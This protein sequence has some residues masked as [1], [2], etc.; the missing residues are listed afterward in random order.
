MGQ[1]REECR[2][3]GRRLHHLLEVVEEA[4]HRLVRDVLGEAV[5]R[6]ERLRRRREDE[7]RIAQRRER[8]PPDAVGIGLGGQAGRLQ[9]KPRLSGAARPGQGEQARVLVER[10]STTSASSRSLPR[11]GVAGTGRFVR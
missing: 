6:A 2:E 9:R 3:L 5:L 11:K 7:R 4:E 10:S 8:H 1:A